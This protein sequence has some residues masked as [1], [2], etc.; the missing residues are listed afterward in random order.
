MDS[1]LLLSGFAIAAALLIT[2]G[3]VQAQSRSPVAVDQIGSAR[4]SRPAAIPPAGTPASRA[5]STIA[6]AKPSVSAPNAPAAPGANSR[7]DGVTPA[8][9]ICI[10]AEAAGLPAPAGCPARTGAAGSAAPTRTVEGG[11]LNLFGSRSVSTTGGTPV[12]SNTANA[13]AIARQAGSQSGVDAGG[14]AAA[15]ASRQRPGAT[16]QGGPPR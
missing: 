8:P 14:D 12:A 6:P 3:A 13:D 11:L 4:P 5:P 16:P 10:R 1:R 15:V 9:E 2:P 7:R